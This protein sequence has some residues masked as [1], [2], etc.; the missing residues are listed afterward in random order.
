[1]PEKGTH[2]PHLNYPCAWVYKIIGTDQ[3]D[4]QNAVSEIIQDRSCNISVS[5][6]S[7]HAKYVSLNVELVVESESHRMALYEAFKAHKAVKVVL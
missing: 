5:R 1:M 4:M 2:K 7:E 3:N 6:L